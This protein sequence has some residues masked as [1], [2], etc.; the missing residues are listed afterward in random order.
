[1][2]LRMQLVVGWLIVAVAVANRWMLLLFGW[3]VVSDF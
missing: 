3:L 2:V 1:M